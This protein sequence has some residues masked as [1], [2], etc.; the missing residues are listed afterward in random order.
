VQIDP[1]AERAAGAAA[2]EYRVLAE[3]D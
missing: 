1:W 3:V 2:H